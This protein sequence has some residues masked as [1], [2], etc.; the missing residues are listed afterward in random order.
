MIER[1][2]IQSAK[3]A[4][5]LPS[6]WEK[7]GWPDS[8]RKSCRVPYRDDSR[9]SGSVFQRGDGSWCFHDFKD[10]ETRDEIGLVA[11]MEGL[12][13]G[14]AIRRFCALAG[15]LDEDQ[16][17]RA[18][19]HVPRPLALTPR[20]ETRPTHKPAL[21]PMR[22]PSLAEC[23]NI[24]ASRGLH[25]ES[26]KLA[27][28]DGLV[29]MSER[30][31]SL[32]WVLTDSARWNAQ[33]RRIDSSPYEIG[34]GRKVK[35]LGAKGGWAAW[36]LGLPSLESAG[37]PLAVI[38]E[39]TPDALAAFQ[40]ISEA[41]LSAVCGV[42]CMTGAGLRI[43][44]ECLPVFKGRRVRIFPHVGDTTKA[45]DEAGLRWECQ[46]QEAG[47]NVDAF[48]LSG[49]IQADGKAVKDLNDACRMCS[50]ER[51]DLGLMEGMQ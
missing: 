32:S 46:L 1:Q 13:N 12:S 27:A 28:C 49:L 33:Y 31:G 51:N 5:P 50:N 9:D 44:A 39:G 10:G 7:L 18:A 20:P 8:P 42:V 24:A 23:A 48:D 40:V 22:E 3:A 41:G 15:V 26:V 21:P 29:F 14:E 19:S 45:G 43:P 17:K 11:I 47:A 37:F 34:D 4:L 2:T 25:P 6:L 36:P 30:L 35:T 38:V 16:T